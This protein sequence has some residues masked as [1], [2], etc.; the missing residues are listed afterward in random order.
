MLTV[1][2]LREWVE[3]DLSDTTLQGLI[4]TA[5]ARVTARTGNPVGEQETLNASGQPVLT[6]LYPIAQVISITERR[7]LLDDAILVDASS[8][9]TI[10]GSRM[11]WRLSAGTT[12]ASTWGEEVVISY[13][14]VPH[15]EAEAAIRDLTLLAVQAP[16]G[17]SQLDDG[18]LSVTTADRVRQE[19]AILAR[20]AGHV[21]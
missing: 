13:E 1:A 19:H 9:R 12:P 20:L 21:A 10:L 8:V 7:T 2:E 4:D 11:I 5:T 14:P 18:S 6:T 15:P 16:M 17:S 3:T